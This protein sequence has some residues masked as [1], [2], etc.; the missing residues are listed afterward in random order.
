[1]R[2]RR[3]LIAGVMVG[4]W[5]L[6][7]QAPQAPIGL[8]PD[9]P[10]Y[11]LS[12]VVRED[13]VEPRVVTV[14]AGKARI[15]VSNRSGRQG[16][17]MRLVRGPAAVTSRVLVRTERRWRETVQLAPGAYVMEAAENPKWR[18]QITVTP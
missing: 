5:C 7:G 8:G 12:F 10:D 9:R 11:L 17:N 3:L 14:R 4:V 2:I 16:L 18:C 15:I 1:M 13:H 6:Q